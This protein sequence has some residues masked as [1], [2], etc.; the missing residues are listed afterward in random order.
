MKMKLPWMSRA[1]RQRWKAARTLP[2]LAELMALWLEGRIDSRPGYQPRY[3][4]DLESTDLIPVLAAANR[5]GYLTDASQP[6]AADTGFDGAWWEQKAAVTGFVADSGLLRRLVA[7]AEAVGL[8]VVLHD[9]LD[10]PGTGD[11]IVTTRD[12]QPYTGFGQALSIKDL[13]LM[14]RGCHRQAVNAVA[15]STQLTLI[16][17]EFGLSVRLWNVLGYIA[18]HPTSNDA[19]PD[20]ARGAGCGRTE[21]TPTAS[22]SD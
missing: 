21:N 18:G 20:D 1:D 3:G 5:A 22:S 17:P 16:D 4:P 10:P 9:L 11:V 19:D 6:G 13:D 7:A 2:D 12:G 8:H 15:E 14:W